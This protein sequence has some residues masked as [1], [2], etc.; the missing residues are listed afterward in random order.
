MRASFWQ[1][2]GFV[3]FLIGAL[4]LGAVWFTPKLSVGYIL[5]GVILLGTTIAI[6]S[7]R[8]ILATSSWSL[9]D[10]LS[11]QSHISVDDPANPGKKIVS[12]VSKSS[13]SRLIAMMGMM[14][15][16]ILYICIGCACVWSLTQDGKFPDSA[17]QG[18][19]FLTSGI[20]LFVPY[21]ANK[22]ASA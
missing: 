11:E 6:L 13:M 5:I 16:L 1:S 18:A 12:S 2:A 9:A 7:I 10:A 20:S 4:V 15:I 3:V 8:D 14:A 22:A 21:V 19:A 17:L